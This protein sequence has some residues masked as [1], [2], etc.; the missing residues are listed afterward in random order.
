MQSA[1]EKGMI[2]SPDQLW[3]DE[4]ISAWDNSVKYQELCDGYSPLKWEKSL[5]GEL[6][7]K[8]YF[9]AFYA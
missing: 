8:R 4:R 1:S 6:S 2:F 7:N 9:S 3:T 5:A